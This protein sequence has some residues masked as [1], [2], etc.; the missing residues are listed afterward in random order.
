[1]AF[2]LFL[3]R[4]HLS[5]F[6]SPPFNSSG[7]RTSLFNRIDIPLL[8]LLCLLGSSFTVYGEEGGLLLAGT[9][10]VEITPDLRDRP[11]AGNGSTVIAEKVRDPIHARC[12]MLQRGETQ[13]VLLVVDV[14]LFTLS[15][16]ER[17]KTLINE[18]TGIP[19]DRIVVSATHTHSVPFP[20]FNAREGETK[21]TLE[22]IARSAVEAHKNLVPAKV[23]WAVGNDPK[24]VFCRRYLMRE[25]TALINPAF[26]PGP[27]RVAMNPGFGNP[28]IVSPAGPVDS[29]IPI[30]SVVSPEGKPV[31]VFA[32]YSSHH[33]TALDEISADRFGVFCKE[34]EQRIAEKLGRD[35]MSERFL[36]LMSTGTCGDA[37]CV[38]Y[39]DP[40]R[41]F[42]MDTVGRD[43]AEGVMRAWSNIE[44]FD[45][46]PLD[47]VERRIDIPCYRP[48]PKEVEAARAHLADE[49]RKK[50][51]L[52]E[53][54]VRDIATTET[55]EKSTTVP[56]QA[57]RIGNLGI[58]TLPGEFFGMTGIEIKAKSPFQPTMNIGLA[59]VSFGYV[60]PPEQYELGGYEAWRNSY[61]KLAVEA[62]PLIKSTL[63]DMLEAL[64]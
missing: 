50:V 24:N 10:L 60:P 35:R 14:C 53:S 64:K 16:T 26:G 11:A 31:A 49:S 2:L 39:L 57:I 37:N 56:L 6:G 19:K 33:A 23:G 9:G 32:N 46:V 42:D 27:D 51:G 61:H 40:E 21:F 63:L 44:Y 22:N 25:G 34:V 20:P 52:V 15:M 43:N 3:Y 58:T 12:L 55:W 59:N 8:A 29:L 7:F 28:N 18:Q 4:S 48:G 5:F 62:E 30:L 47:M 41:K 45:D 38:N 13:V 1:M 54:F 17:I 36:A